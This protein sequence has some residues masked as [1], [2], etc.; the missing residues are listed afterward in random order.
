MNTSSA[1]KNNVI[2]FLLRISV[3]Q[4]EG[5]TVITFHRLTLGHG[6][7]S[8]G[9]SHRTLA[10][11]Y[12]YLDLPESKRWQLYG[13]YLTIDNANNPRVHEG[14]STSLSIPSD[15]TLDRLIDVEIAKKDWR[16]KILVVFPL[17]NQNKIPH[18][19]I[20]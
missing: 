16:E 8:S 6:Y 4:H 3:G 17:L 11:T 18:L 14:G 12:G 1:S 19:Q 7:Q 13:G 2:R 20:A 9:T 5:S 10:S 15:T